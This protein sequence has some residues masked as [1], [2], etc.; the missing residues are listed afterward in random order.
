[1]FS[2]NQLIKLASAKRRCSDLLIIETK[3]LMINLLFFRPEKAV[4]AKEESSETERARNLH[5]HDQAELVFR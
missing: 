1:M 4:K 2:G 3:V 5:N